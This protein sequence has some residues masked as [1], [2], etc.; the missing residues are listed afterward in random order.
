NR[1]K[2]SH[3]PQ[4]PSPAAKPTPTRDSQNPPPPELPNNFDIRI[5]SAA[6]FAQIIWEVAQA[7]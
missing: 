2:G 6:S 7:Y 3:Q 1:Y 4:S 5:I